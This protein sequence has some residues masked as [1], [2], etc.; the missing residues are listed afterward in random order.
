MPSH[1]GIPENDLVYLAAKNAS[2]QGIFTEV[3]W[4]IKDV[5]V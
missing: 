3:S 1:S 5:S 2:K 4:T